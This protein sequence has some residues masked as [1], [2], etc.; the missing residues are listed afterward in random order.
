MGGQEVEAQET[1]TAKRGKFNT[2]TL[3][4]LFR[5]VQVKTLFPFN[6]SDKPFHSNE[7][8]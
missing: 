3:I 7:Q 4:E 5:S 8:N 2:L 6:V 1:I